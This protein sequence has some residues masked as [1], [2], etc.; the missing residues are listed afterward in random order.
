MHGDI[1]TG[2]TPTLE[3]PCLDNEPGVRP[4]AVKSVDGRL[5]STCPVF[6]ARVHECMQSEFPKW[7]EPDVVQI[8]A[9]AS[10]IAE[11]AWTVARGAFLREPGF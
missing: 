11:R 5:L 2:A 8:K 3:Q 4:A 1:D 10:S 9:H 7:P 6:K